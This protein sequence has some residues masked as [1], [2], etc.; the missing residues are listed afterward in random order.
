MTKLPRVSGKNLVSVLQKFGFR[1]LRVKGS[2]HILKHPDGRQT[3]VPVHRNEILGP[4]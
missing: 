2:H 3:V 4:G 1:V